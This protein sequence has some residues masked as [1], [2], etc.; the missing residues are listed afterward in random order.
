MTQYKL[1]EE[2][3]EHEGIT[4]HRIELTADCQWGKRVIR[5]IRV[6]GFN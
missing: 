6:V 2:T 3:K 5:V 1:T 4:L